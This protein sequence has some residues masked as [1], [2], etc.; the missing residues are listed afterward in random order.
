MYVSCI[1]YIKSESIDFVY[2]CDFHSI[3]VGIEIPHM[4]VH[5]CIHVQKQA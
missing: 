4:H 3:Y 5:K 2:A 1:T